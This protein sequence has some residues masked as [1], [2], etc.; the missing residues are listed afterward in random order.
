M[1]ELVFE[2]L[3]SLNSCLFTYENVG[4]RFGGGKRLEAF[5]QNT[6]V[7]QVISEYRLRRSQGGHVQ[8]SKRVCRTMEEHH[9]RSV[10]SWV[11]VTEDKFKESDSGPLIAFVKEVCGMKTA[12]AHGFDSSLW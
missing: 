12:P 11:A 5:E 9:L 10:V 4:D 8:G 6:V 3:R 2:I 1:F 7:P